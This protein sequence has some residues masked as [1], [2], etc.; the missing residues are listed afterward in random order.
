MRKLFKENDLVKVVG[1]AIL[2]TVVLTWVVKGGTFAMNETGKLAFMSSED[3]VRTGLTELTLSGVYAVSF[4]LQQMVFVL[5]LGAFYGILSLTNGYKRLVKECA[6]FVKG[7]EIPVVLCVSALVALFVSISSQIY[8]S[9]IA[10]PFIITVLLNANLDK[11]TAF[12]ATFG[13]IFV[14]MIGATYGTEGLYFFNYYM[15]QDITKEVSI[16]FGVLALAYVA[17][18]FINVLHI[19]NVLASKKTVNETKEDVFAVEEP[20]KKN[21]KIWPIAT[22]LLVTFT[23][24]VLGYIRWEEQFKIKTFTK[25]HKNLMEFKIGK[26]E[27][28]AHLLGNVNALGTWEIYSILGV[29][30]IVSIVAAIIYKLSIDDYIKGAAD[31]IAKMIKPVVLMVLGYSVFVLI[32]WSPIVPKIVNDILTSKFEIFPT[33]ISAAVTSFFTADFG[34]TGYTIGQYLTATYATKMKEVVLIFSTMHGFVQTFAPTSVILLLGLSYTKV[35]YKDWI[36]H[37]WKYLVTMLIALFIIF[38]AL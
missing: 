36:A 12:V 15:G 34:Y 19:R 20:T 38:V 31:G 26:K 6:K 29:L 17:F 10:L 25:F 7:K 24:A 18:T 35:S 9:L 13:S 21:A 28:F 5:L 30:L 32:Y 11:K 14:G 8:I 27:I 4:F 37:I 1:L 23:F 3:Y 22:L 16:R 2:F 33:A